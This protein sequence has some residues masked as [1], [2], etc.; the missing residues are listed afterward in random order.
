MALGDRGHFGC[1]LTTDKY[2]T[3]AKSFSTDVNHQ[4][5]HLFMSTENLGVIRICKTIYLICLCGIV[6]REAG[7][8]WG[9]LLLCSAGEHL[10]AWEN[11]LAMGHS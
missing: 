1:L 5:A 8:P 9:D 2:L 4:I 6:P 3:T 7:K 11:Q 10:A